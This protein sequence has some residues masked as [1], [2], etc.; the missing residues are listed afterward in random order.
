MQRERPPE[1]AEDAWVDVKRHVAPHRRRAFLWQALGAFLFPARCAACRQFGPH[2]F[3]TDA[4]SGRATDALAPVRGLLCADCLDTCQ[5]LQSPMCSRCGLMFASRNIEDHRCSD[6]LSGRGH[7]GMARAVGIHQG[8]LMALVHQLKYQRRLALISPMGRML[9]DTFQRYWH[10]RPVDLALPIPL[11][12]KRLRQRGFNQAALLLRATWQQAACDAARVPRISDRVPMLVRARSTPP[13][14]GLNRRERQRNIRGAFSVTDR[15]G[16]KGQRL[17][18]L[19]DVFTTGAT[20]EEAAR[21]LLKAGADSV[22]VLT[23][24]RTLI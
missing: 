17:L 10:A 22:D 12:P 14:T 6:C 21:V 24:A 4:E 2:P 20:V 3:D 9:R 8:S 1:C 5:L 15:D 7:Y 16:I 19:D 13:Q 11:H 23:F 18:L